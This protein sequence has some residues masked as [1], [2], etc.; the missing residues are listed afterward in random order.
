[1]IDDERHCSELVW[2]SV[3]NLDSRLLLPFIS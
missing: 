2:G 1:M 3:G